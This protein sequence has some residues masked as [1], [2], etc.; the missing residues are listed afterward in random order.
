MKI[1]RLALAFVFGLVL[2]GGTLAGLAR[3]D[4]AAY[5]E[6]VL[7]D[8]SELE[9]IHMGG[10]GNVWIS[11]YDAGQVWQIN[12]L[13]LA[14][15]RFNGLP[16]VTDAQFGPGGYVWSVSID[17]NALGRLEIATGQVTTWTLGIS[18]VNGLAVD[19]QGRVWVGAYHQSKLIRFDPLSHQRCDFTLLNNLGGYMVDYAGAIWYGDEGTG[20]GRLNTTTNVN[21]HWS[22]GISDFG[23]WSVGAN[24][25]AGV[26]FVD[27]S[28]GMVG[29]LD[30][31]LNTITAYTSSL[32][33]L[34]A[35]MVVP[36]GSNIWFT[37][38]SGQVVMLDP[39]AGSGTTTPL[40][41]ANSTISPAC[42]DAG[43]G[44]NSAVSNTT[45]GLGFNTGTF[46]TTVENGLTHYFLPAGSNPY[47]LTEVN[48]DLWFVDLDRGTVTILEAQRVRLPLVTR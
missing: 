48:G 11:D 37:D 16:G 31:N 38:F 23:A 21:T 10:D 7:R 19:E 22:F 3:A 33:L 44:V 9:E 39:A 32:T 5:R 1:V 28:Q 42:V 45:G 2:V 35:E 13:T 29:H 17:N 25:A 43:A 14:Y 20:L 18:S 34:G 36:R 15:K 26:W 6:A 24:D 30:P 27:D 12:P 40:S 4:G 41:S 46:T 8:A 47:G